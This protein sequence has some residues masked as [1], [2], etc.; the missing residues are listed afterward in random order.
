[1]VWTVLGWMLIGIVGF[2]LLVGV[3]LVI[4][5]VVIGIRENAKKRGL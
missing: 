1:M 2:A 4:A 5:A 3:T